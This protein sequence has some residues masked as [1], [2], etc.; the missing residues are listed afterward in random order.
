ML[1]SFFD[2]FIFTNNLKYK[3]NNFYLV[4]LPFLI[5]PTELIASLTLS[6]D[7]EMDKK[8]YASVK[9]TTRKK[10]IPQFTLDP[11]LTPDKTLKLLEDFFSAA[12]WGQIKNADL[13]PKKKRAIVVISHAPR[14]LP[15]T[16]S[17]AP[18][19]HFLRGIL[20]GIFSD[21]FK[22]DMDCIET[23]CIA[24]GN[25]TCQFILKKAGK[26]DLTK[27]DAKEQLVTV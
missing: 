18:I 16:K 21:Y 9:E 14:S 10:M 12:G 23:D 8:I 7:A 13:D 24:E 20:A 25:R 15:K 17:D 27:E 5:I 26:F 3:H 22:T 1:N 6:T 4:K 19:H 11:D 2:K